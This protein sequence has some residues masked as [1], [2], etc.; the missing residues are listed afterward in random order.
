MFSFTFSS[1]AIATPTIVG[2]LC[3]LF[4]LSPMLR[5]KSN[6]SYGLT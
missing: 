3:S 1:I 4:A 2:Y 6:A 5:E